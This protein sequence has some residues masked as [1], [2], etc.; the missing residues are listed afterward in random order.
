[1]TV[2]AVRTNRICNKIVTVDLILSWCV[3]LHYML[4]VV[5]EIENEVHTQQHA[6][7]FFR[8][9]YN[10]LVDPHQLSQLLDFSSHIRSKNHHVIWVPSCLLPHSLPEIA[11]FHLFL[12]SGRK[13]FAI[14]WGSDFDN[15]LY[16]FLKSGLTQ[17]FVCVVV[18]ISGSFFLFN[19]CFFQTIQPFLFCLT[20]FILLINIVGILYHNVRQNYVSERQRLCLSL[21]L[22]VL[23]G[24]QMWG[25]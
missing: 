5:K 6:F 19:F 9:W 23:A 17:P 21:V 13:M 25:L 20:F 10:R 4:L 12:L 3:K 24:L 7:V 14:L 8:A 11:P 1:M 22:S 15:S 2:A 16:F 18:S